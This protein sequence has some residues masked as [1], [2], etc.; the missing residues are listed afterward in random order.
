M[1]AVNGK[2][3]E[4]FQGNSSLWVRIFHLR[5]CKGFKSILPE[6]YKIQ[7]QVVERRDIYFVFV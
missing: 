2:N 3:E 6:V 1:Y 5:R 7:K 4:A